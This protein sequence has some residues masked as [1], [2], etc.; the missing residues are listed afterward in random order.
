MYFTSLD[1]GAFFVATFVLYYL[2]ISRRFQIELLVAASLFIYG[3]KQAI[4]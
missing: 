1:F 2:P 3:W 4:S